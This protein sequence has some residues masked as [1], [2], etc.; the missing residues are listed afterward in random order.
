MKSN[1]TLQELESL[2]TL[3]VGQAEDLKVETNDIRIWLSRCG[4]ADGEPHNNMVTVE[5]YDEAGGWYTQRRY[6]AK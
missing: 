5:K 6:Q 4:V 3:C 1:Y 2:P